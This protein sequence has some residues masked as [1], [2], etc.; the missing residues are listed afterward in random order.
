MANKGA[1]TGGS[2]ALIVL[3]M[4]TSPASANDVDAGYLTCRL[5]QTDAAVHL[6]SNRNFDCTFER[7]RTKRKEH[8]RGTVR[9]YGVEVGLIGKRVLRWKVLKSTP[10]RLKR[11]AL[12]G[13]YR[14]IT[15]ETSFGSG[16]AVNLLSS[17][18][19]G[20]V[21]LQPLTVHGQEGFNVT[22]G[23]MIL[24]LTSSK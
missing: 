11:G 14:G 7:H 10:R 24:T 12:A 16:V 4:L 18:A 9:K 2:V 13:D 8:Y 22:A 23:V 15:A 21:S 6:A 19:S 20:Q 17:S 5:T 3:A 1:R